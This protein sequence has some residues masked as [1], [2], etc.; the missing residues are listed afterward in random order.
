M[1]DSQRPASVRAAVGSD[2]DEPKMGVTLQTDRIDTNSP[3]S[4]NLALWLEPFLLRPTCTL[5]P[6]D[7]QNARSCRPACY[8]DEPSSSKRR[9]SHL[10]AHPSLPT[11]HTMLGAHHAKLDGLCYLPLHASSVTLHRCARSTGWIQGRTGRF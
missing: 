8:R 5:R 1:A 10:F 9:Y 3:T 4:W 6:D 2:G 7:V 11:L